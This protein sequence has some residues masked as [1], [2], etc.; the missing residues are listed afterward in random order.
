L[1]YSDESIIDEVSLHLN[2]FSSNPTCLNYYFAERSIKLQ[3]LHHFALRSKTKVR[4]IILLLSVELLN[5]KETIPWSSEH[6]LQFV[7][8]S[9]Q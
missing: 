8:A 1:D 3:D 9:Q 4:W 5:A 2:I 6:I 7:S